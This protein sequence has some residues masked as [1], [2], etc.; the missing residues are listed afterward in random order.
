MSEPDLYEYAIG[1]NWRKLAGERLALLHTAHRR[2]RVSLVV[3]VLLV[4]LV[5]VIACV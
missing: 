2:L 5:V 3:I 4:A 1:E